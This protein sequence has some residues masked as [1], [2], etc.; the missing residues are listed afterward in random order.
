VPPAQDTELRVCALGGS[1][2]T[3]AGGI[4]AEVVEVRNWESLE[5]LADS[6]RGKIVFLNRPMPPDRLDTFDAYGAAADQRAWG[7]MRA[8]KVGAVAVLVRSM[9][10]SLTR[11]C[12]TG[13]MVYK[14]EEAP[15]IPAA[16]L[17][18]LDAD[19]LS[20]VLARQGTAR[21]RL[22]MGCSE[23]GTVQT[24]NTMGELTGSEHPEE[25][26]VLGGHIDSWDLGPGAHDDGAGCVQALDALRI[27]KQLG[28]KP[29][30][31]IRAVMFMDEEFGG[32]GGKAYAHDSARKNE[33]HVAAVESDRGGFRPLAFTVHG[34]D[35]AVERV[36][37]WLPDLGQAGIFTVEK[38]YGGVDIEP[39]SESGTVTIGLV[40][41][42]QRYFD[43]HHCA[44]DTLDQVNP[45]ELGLG[46]A[47]MAILAW[48][49]S[50]EGL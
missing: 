50:E 43:M 4:T 24:A 10:L 35:P 34:S 13:V 5:K 32:A 17:A 45:R 16:A 18:T 12:H 44:N 48:K 19:L 38:G 23:P 49:L 11:H 7:A 26:V 46:A 37:S 41:E 20:A 22:E 3:P 29:R 31:T 40:P 2:G 27:L 9:T 28:L 8:A 47:A 1:I 14:D 21:V 33:K 15:R 39:L 30:R 6:A 42:S 25:V 36:R